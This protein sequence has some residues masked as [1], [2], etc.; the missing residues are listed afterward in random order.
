MTGQDTT[1]ASVRQL[2]RYRRHALTAAGQLPAV[3]RIAAVTL[4]GLR[5]GSCWHRKPH[6]LPGAPR[7]DSRH[8]GHPR[9]H[10]AASGGGTGLAPRDTTN[11]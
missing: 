2:T 1:A 4:S 8:A 10:G 6:A 9:H 3:R 5:A 7:R 11:Q